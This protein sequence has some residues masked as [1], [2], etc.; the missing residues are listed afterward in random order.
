[1]KEHHE[2]YLKDENNCCIYGGVYTYV[3]KET[4]LVQQDA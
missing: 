2:E 4:I 1:M 3:Q